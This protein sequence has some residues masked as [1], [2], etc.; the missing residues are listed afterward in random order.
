MELVSALCEAPV[1]QCA[2]IPRNVL[3]GW[4]TKE[5]PLVW[6]RAAFGVGD[7]CAAAPCPLGHCGAQLLP[8]PCLG[9]WGWRHWI[10][11]STDGTAGGMLWGGIYASCSSPWCCA[12]LAAAD[13][14]AVPPPPA[15]NRGRA[16]ARA[17]C[18]T[19]MTLPSHHPTT[20]CP[21]KPSHRRTSTPS[22]RGHTAWPCPPSPR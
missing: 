19:K 16:A 5:R 7:T 12:V 17:T 20:A 13:S 22:S 1:G 4:D 3:F 11:M 9:W 2:R 18:S 14:P 6:R 8:V 10:R 15:C 21:H